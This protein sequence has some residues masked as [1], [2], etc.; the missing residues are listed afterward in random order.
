MRPQQ[1]FIMEARCHCGAAL[2]IERRMDGY[3]TGSA[4]SAMDLAASNFWHEHKHADADDIHLAR[5]VA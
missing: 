4:A 3:E 1:E 5:R 2:R